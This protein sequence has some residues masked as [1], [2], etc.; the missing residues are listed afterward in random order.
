MQLGLFTFLKSFTMLTHGIIRNSHD[1]LKKVL[2][3]PATVWH[4]YMECEVFSVVAS[5]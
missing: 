3:V 2:E 1:L 5:V 4:F